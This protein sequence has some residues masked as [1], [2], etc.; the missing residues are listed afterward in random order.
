MRPLLTYPL[1]SAL[2]VLGAGF[3]F[4][5]A[6]MS[7]DP[8]PAAYLHLFASIASPYALLLALWG[9]RRAHDHKRALLTVVGIFLATCCLAFFFFAFLLS[10]PQVVLLFGFRWAFPLFIVMTV[11]PML[12]AIW[13]HYK[14]MVKFS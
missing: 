8:P 6:G 1:S 2:F 14:D 12:I 13:V 4:S 11:V 10:F 9:V 7:V 3:L 5:V